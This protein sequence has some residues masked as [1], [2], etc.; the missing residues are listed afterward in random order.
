MFVIV[1]ITVWVMGVPLE[2][3]VGATKSDIVRSGKVPVG[4]GVGVFVG[5]MGGFVAVGVGVGGASYLT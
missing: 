3:A 2:C 5:P 1:S 4:V